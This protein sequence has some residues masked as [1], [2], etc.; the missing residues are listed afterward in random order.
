MRATRRLGGE[1]VRHQ[2]WVDA[3][4]TVANLHSGGFTM[5]RYRSALAIAVLLA[6]L[7]TATPVLAQQ[8]SFQAEALWLQ[9]DVNPGVAT[10]VEDDRDIVALGTNNLG[11]GFS[12]G[13][14]F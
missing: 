8:W 7:L 4:E 6:A 12:P 11:F 5:R 13:A 1:V 14:R 2:G 10:S 9:R 3:V